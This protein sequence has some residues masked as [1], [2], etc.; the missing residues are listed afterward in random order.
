MPAGFPQGRRVDRDRMVRTQLAARGI[1]DPAVLQAMA[2]VPRE[3][4]VPPELTAQAY[5]DT[6]LPIGHGQTISQPYIVARMTEDLALQGMEKVLDVGTG[7]GYQTAI[8][9]LLAERVFSIE[10]DEHLFRQAADRLQTLGFQNVTCLHGDGWEGSP[11]EA[12]FQGILV[13]AAARKRPQALMEQLDEGGRLIVPLEEAGGEQ[14]LFK[15]QRQSDRW[16]EEGLTMVR[17]VPLL[18]GTC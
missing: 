5:E 8:L 13:A 10:R 7:S 4:F 15:I 16:T 6:P 3:L 11:G 12:P 1:T 9:S 2:S 18:P 14:T 17:F